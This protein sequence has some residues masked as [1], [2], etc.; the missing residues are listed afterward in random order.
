[1]AKILVIVVGLLVAYWLLKRYSKSLSGGDDQAPPGGS[2][3]MVRCVK[4]GLHLPKSESIVVKSE[5]FCSSE[6]ARERE[7]NGE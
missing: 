5:H 7:R 3:D 4:C 1:V 2:E 6:H